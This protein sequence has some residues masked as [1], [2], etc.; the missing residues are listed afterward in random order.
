MSAAAELT[1]SLDTDLVKAVE[2]ADVSLVSSLL[3]QGARP[4]AVKTYRGIGGEPV[5]L[6]A[7]RQG[8][9]AIAAL[10]LE[11]G[12]E[13]N[14]RM[15]MAAALFIERAFKSQ[16]KEQQAQAEQLFH[17]LEGRGVDWTA[18]DRFVGG[19]LRAI[20]LVQA[21]RPGLA[22]AAAQRLGVDFL[23]PTAP[24]AQSKGRVRK[25]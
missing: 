11:A 15:V 12:A 3:Y 8:Q 9:P 23:M 1:P 19:G 17:L 21:S 16:N 4:Q 6:L 7:I 14:S 18:S 5:L 13:L 25:S 10:L 20:D 2:L 24:A 22:E